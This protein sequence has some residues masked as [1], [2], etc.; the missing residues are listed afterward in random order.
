[1]QPP[2]TPLAIILVE[3]HPDVPAGNSSHRVAY[4]RNSVSQHSSTEK[5]W[6]AHS[7]NRLCKGILMS[8]DSRIHTNLVATHPWYL[9]HSL[10]CSA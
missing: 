7:K 10:D 6:H 3:V 1:M 8:Q 9:T 5:A 4:N 2:C